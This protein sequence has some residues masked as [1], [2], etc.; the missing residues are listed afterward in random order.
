LVLLSP[1]LIFLKRKAWLILLS[2]LLQRCF[3]RKLL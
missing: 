2:S 1:V 3:A